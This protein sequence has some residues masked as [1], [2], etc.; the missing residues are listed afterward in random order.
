MTTSSRLS[1]NI[2]EVLRDKD[3]LACFMQYMESRKVGALIK[4]WCD[5]ESFQ[6]ATWSRIR[7]HSLNVTKQQTLSERSK[8]S[9]VAA[10]RDGDNDSNS[11]GSSLTLHDESPSQNSES[12]QDLSTLSTPNPS[13]AVVL[14]TGQE[15]DLSSENSVISNSNS[16]SCVGLDSNRDCDRT[17]ML[18]G[19]GGGLERQESMM[20]EESKPLGAMMTLSKNKPTSLST[21][22]LAEKLKKSKYALK[23][24]N[25]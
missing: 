10:S 6:A 19:E 17:Q 2:N 5:A 21:S 16:T 8:Q 12:A 1:K 13:G 23:T 4:F 22:D 11:I 20:S 7:T 18:C 9:E 15:K 24:V 25:L 3:A 14:D